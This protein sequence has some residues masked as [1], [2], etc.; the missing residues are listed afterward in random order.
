MER[1]FKWQI[2]NGFKFDICHC[3]AFYIFFS[4]FEILM[5]GGGTAKWTH[6]K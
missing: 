1:D 4:P 2:S 5:T 3:C 6:V